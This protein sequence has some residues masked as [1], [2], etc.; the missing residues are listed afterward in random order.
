MVSKIIMYVMYIFENIF[1]INT[2]NNINTEI[3][4]YKSV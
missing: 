1:Y 3:V 4:C 2:H